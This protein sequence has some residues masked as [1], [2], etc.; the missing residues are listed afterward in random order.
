VLLDLNLREKFYTAE[1]LRRCCLQADILKMSEAELI[2]AR[3]MLG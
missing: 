2:I 3:T 1:I